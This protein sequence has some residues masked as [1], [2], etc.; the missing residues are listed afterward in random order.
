[1]VL[2]GGGN[3][4]EKEIKILPPLAEKNKRKVKILQVWK[5][6]KNSTWLKNRGQ[7]S[8]MLEREG[9]TF[10]IWLLKVGVRILHRLKKGVKGPSLPI[11][12]LACVKCEVCSYCLTTLLYHR[13]K[14]VPDLPV[15]TCTLLEGITSQFADSK[16]HVAH[17]GP[18]GS[19]RPQV[20]P[21]WAP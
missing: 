20:G 18:P 13:H 7:N 8:T 12:C 16:V 2:K 9:S 6:G 11:T 5:W 3:T 15:H 10:D 21:M 17:M 4:C 14:T 1:M 19:C